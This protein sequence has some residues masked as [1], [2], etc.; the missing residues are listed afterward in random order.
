[1]AGW[2]RE[3]AA[4]AIYLLGA[5]GAAAIETAS[6]QNEALSLVRA[7]KQIREVLWNTPADLWVSMSDDGSRRDGFAEYLCLAVYEGTSIP[8]QTYFLI[9]IWA[10]QAM[11]AGNL[12]EIGRAPC[13]LT[14]SPD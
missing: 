14:H 7:E 8:D 12:T 11:K 4:L 10:A 13:H 1:M 5:G 3:V 9:H 2:N 6:W